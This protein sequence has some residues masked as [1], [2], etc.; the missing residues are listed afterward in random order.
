MFYGASVFAGV[1]LDPTDRVPGNNSDTG[2]VGLGSG[3]ASMAGSPVQAAQLAALNYGVGT[4]MPGRKR[5]GPGGDGSP[6]SPDP[7]GRGRPSGEAS[8]KGGKDQKARKK[9]DPTPLLHVTQ[10]PLR[11]DIPVD[12]LNRF[13]Q[14]LSS[15]AKAHEGCYVECVLGDTAFLVF[16][17]LSHSFN[18]GAA[19]GAAAA[20]LSNA[21]VWPGMSMFCGIAGGPARVGVI[22]GTFGAH[23]VVLGDCMTKASALARCAFALGPTVGTE[24]LQDAFTPF[25]EDRSFRAQSSSSSRPPPHPN[26]SHSKLPSQ[27]GHASVPRRHYFAKLRQQQ[28]FLHSLLHIPGRALCDWALKDEVK[29]SVVLRLVGHLPQ[30][31][32][33]EIAGARLRY[34]CPEAVGIPLPLAWRSSGSRM[35]RQYSVSMLQ[36][37]MLVRVA[38]SA[39]HDEAVAKL[40][41]RIREGMVS[42]PGPMPLGASMY[43]GS[44]LHSPAAGNRGPIVAGLGFSTTGH[45]PGADI[46]HNGYFG[47]STASEA[48]MLGGHSG[49]YT[50]DPENFVWSESVMQSSESFVVPQVGQASSSGHLEA[51][52]AGIMAGSATG[53]NHRHGSQLSVPP[54]LSG[55]RD[56]ALGGP[57][58]SSMS[59]SNNSRSGSP[60]AIP[61][62]RHTA[63]GD[64][65]ALPSPMATSTLASSPTKLDG[66]SRPPLASALQMPI[67]TPMSRRGSTTSRVPALP[68]LYPF[69][70]PK[71]GRRGGRHRRTDTL[72]D[73]DNPESVEDEEVDDDLIVDVVGDDIGRHRRLST[74]GRGRAQAPSDKDR[75][76]DGSD[77]PPDSARS[78]GSGRGAVRE[79]HRTAERTAG[80]SSGG[81]SDATTAEAAAAKKRRTAAQ[82]ELLQKR[83]RARAAAKNGREDYGVPP[84][85]N[86]PDLT[87]Q[88][89]LLEAEFRG[90]VDRQTMLRSHMA[91][92]AGV[93]MSPSATHIKTPPGAQSPRVGSGTHLSPGLSHAMA[94]GNASRS[95]HSGDADIDV[96][97]MGSHLGSFQL[98]NPCLPNGSSSGGHSGHRHSANDLSAQG[99]GH[100]SPRRKFDDG[101]LPVPRVGAG[102]TSSPPRA[103]R[104]GSGVYGGMSGFNTPSFTASPAEADALGTHSFRGTELPGAVP[105]ARPPAHRRQSMG[106]P[107]EAK[108]VTST[109]GGSTGPGSVPLSRAGTQILGSAASAAPLMDHR[110]LSSLPDLSRGAT[111]SSP[112]A[113]PVGLASLGSES[114]DRRRSAS[115]AAPTPALVGLSSP[116]G[117][118]ALPLAFA[119]AASGTM[120]PQTPVSQGGWNNSFE[121]DR[122]FSAV[123]SPTGPADITLRRR[124]SSPFIDGARRP[125][126]LHPATVGSGGST[127]AVSPAAGSLAESPG[128]GSRSVG[129]A[130]GSGAPSSWSPSAPPHQVSPGRLPPSVPLSLPQYQHPGVSPQIRQLSGEPIR[131][132]SRGSSGR[133]SS[134]PPRRTSPQVSVGTSSTQSEA[135]RSPG[136]QGNLSDLPLVPSPRGPGPA[137]PPVQTPGM[138]SFDNGTTPARQHPDAST[139]SLPRLPN[140][141]G[142]PAPGATASVG[143]SLPY[144][145]SVAG[146]LSQHPGA[147]SGGPGLLQDTALPSPSSTVHVGL[148][149]HT[150]HS[151]VVAAGALSSVGVRPTS[152]GSVRS[153]NGTTSSFP[154]DTGHTAP[155]DRAG[156]LKSTQEAKGSTTTHPSGLGAS[157]HTLHPH[158]SDNATALQSSEDNTADSGNRSRQ[159]SSL[160]PQ[161]ELSPFPLSHHR[162]SQDTVAGVSLSG[163]GFLT[164]AAGV[165][166]GASSSAYPPGRIRGGSGSGTTAIFSESASTGRPPPAFGSCATTARPVGE[167]Y[168]HAGG[169]TS[170]ADAAALM[171]SSHASHNASLHSMAT[172]RL[173]PRPPSATTPL[174]G[175]ARPLRSPA[176][177]GLDVNPPRRAVPAGSRAGRIGDSA[178]PPSSPSAPP[179]PQSQ[180]PA[181][182]HLPASAEHTAAYGKLALSMETAGSQRHDGELSTLGGSSRPSSSLPLNS[183]LSTVV[184]SGTN[185]GPRPSSAAAGSQ[186]QTTS[187]MRPHSAQGSSLMQLGAMT[188]SLLSASDNSRVGGGTGG[189]PVSRFQN[190]S[191][192]QQHLADVSGNAPSS[193]DATPIAHV[194]S[195]VTPVVSGVFAG[196]LMEHS[197]LEKSGSAR[198][199]GGPQNAQR[200]PPVP[201][202]VGP[203]NLPHPSPQSPTTQSSSRGG[204]SSRSSPHVLS[205]GSPQGYSN[206]LPQSGSAS[207]AT[208]LSNASSGPRL[209]AP[210]QASGTGDGGTGEGTQSH[211][212]RGPLLSLVGSVGSSNAH[213]P[214]SPTAHPQQAPPSVPTVPVSHDSAH[215]AHRAVRDPVSLR[216]RKQRQ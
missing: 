126:P 193:E 71:G 93:Q 132:S 131:P 23:S 43:W 204:Q 94:K 118:P 32:V 34:N 12:A 180:S 97:A 164:A 192:P 65:G 110:T 194:E 181:S 113:V 129:S 121:P 190:A 35:L 184:A 151:A 87:L 209:P 70:D 165:S 154:A 7:A 215:P 175:A 39:R 155:E 51:G 163:G 103:G 76:G 60:P 162:S 187:S 168:V 61:A 201:A 82:E 188:S 91:W 88:N 18:P 84:T 30:C 29:D 38:L 55:G 45:I 211:D 202:I 86:G 115:T 166:P 119:R 31:L 21:P 1:P 67:V 208:P 101:T 189:L 57:L 140:V 111:L 74:S 147:C 24:L 133:E 216:L 186:P 160:V 161:V 198:A 148:G 69:Q 176:E 122:H 197:N 46:S 212:S 191:N 5:P 77:T 33:A 128:H 68:G 105:P 117:G 26:S 136:R 199:Q 149:S 79:R 178:T 81:G 144:P 15:V 59:M 182:S 206:S 116:S 6:A 177:M 179:T 112:S 203:P 195:G 25:E 11:S 22:T 139:S 56:A 83:R 143:Y 98:P 80:D 52:P 78:V 157:Q 102:H 10:D 64:L 2:A 138:V 47:E 16:N 72:D 170:A 114:L 174:T 48:M 3:D 159:H 142:A 196:S 28:Q 134:L 167:N 183:T 96:G 205:G 135:A 36:T 8:P 171:S 104:R 106:S 200:P 19:A 42:A 20:T 95:W 127:G 130:S 14:A 108:H 137:T 27:G 150:Q 9:Y 73:D 185:G 141:F 153:G 41:E 123:S 75:K 49:L 213:P 62:L 169:L 109:T 152:G 156:A 50:D 107:L 13:H 44:T 4:Q 37:V 120:S 99:S 89:D 66:H 173:P 58:A 85:Y 90:D 63:G 207:G 124:V 40:K 214:A 17:G 54:Q 53:S 172:A 145:F 158:S 92:H 146:S 100:L 210:G 125:P